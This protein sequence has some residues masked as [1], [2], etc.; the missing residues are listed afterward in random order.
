[1]I[2]KVASVEKAI[3]VASAG[4][5]F[6]EHE[7]SQ[8]RDWF[9]APENWDIRME[10]AQKALQHHFTGRAWPAYDELL[11]A[12]DLRYM[13]RDRRREFD[14]AGIYSHKIK[15]YAWGLDTR[16][17][18][19]PH[20]KTHPFWLFSPVGDGT[21]WP[22]CLAKHGHVDQAAEGWFSDR[23]PCERLWCRCRAIGITAREAEK[24][25]TTSAADVEKGR[26]G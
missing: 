20:T 9:S 25:M 23:P 6:S 8:V 3:V 4:L 16:D 21:T 17:R 10:D 13:L 5:E 24:R 22:D 12:F 15:L 19:L 18:M 1:M 7:R 2:A 11:Q 26:R 14:M